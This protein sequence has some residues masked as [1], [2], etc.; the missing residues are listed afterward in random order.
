MNPSPNDK[1]HDRT[2][3][4]V[5]I[6]ER[7]AGNP[8]THVVMGV[9]VLLLDLVTGPYLWFPVFFIVPV[10]LA[11]WYCGARL[12]YSLAVL[13][14]LGRLL[15]A[16]YVDTPGPVHFAVLNA[17]VRVG[18][19]ILFAYLVSRIARQTKELRERVAGL[20]TMCAWSRTIEHEGRWLSFEEYLKLRFDVDV[21]HGIS[22]EEARKSFSGINFDDVSGGGTRTSDGAEGGTGV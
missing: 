1:G 18:V 21:T 7:L 20:V 6:W 14:P 5:R 3:L 19:L 8:I 11:A 2:V 15:I 13:L 9:T 17:L 4:P 10:S 12:G 22:P 16:V